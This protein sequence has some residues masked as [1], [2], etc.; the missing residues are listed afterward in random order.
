[1]SGCGCGGSID[2]DRILRE[3]EEA[4][5]EEAPIEVTE[6]F[7]RIEKREEVEAGR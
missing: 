2:W 6:E 4:N 7:E 5:E 1:M 3:I